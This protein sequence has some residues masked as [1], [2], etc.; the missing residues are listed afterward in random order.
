[1]S[2][3]KSVKT[4]AIP[5][6]LIASCGMNCRLCRAYTRDRN[7]CAGCRGEDSF[8]FQYCVSRRI[9]NCEKMTKGRINYC[10]SCSS[11]PCARLKRLDKRYRNKYGMSMVDNL[12][13]IKQYGIR[14]FIRAEKEKWTCPEC[15]EI[16]C[17]HK[18]QCLFCAY[19]WQ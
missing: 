8:K 18:P 15:G 5:T 3:Q 12:R 17:C 9:K 16:I 7:A 14:Y 11:F 1:M 19:H 6:H 4:K 2:K 10:F 13:N